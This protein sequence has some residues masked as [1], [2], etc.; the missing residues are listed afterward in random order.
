M[1]KKAGGGM[2]SVKIGKRRKAVIEWAAVLLLF[3]LLSVFANITSALVLSLFVAFLILNVE[4]GIPLFAA[5][6]LLLVSTILLALDQNSGASFVANWAFFML[7][8]GIVLQ[9]I[10]F[11]RSNGRKKDRQTD[12]APSA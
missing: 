5:L 7:A 9:F 4:S 10:D 8:I 12:E 2:K 11:V 3:I 6:I 1:S